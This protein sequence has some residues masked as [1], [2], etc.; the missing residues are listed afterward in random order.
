MNSLVKDADLRDTDGSTVPSTAIANLLHAA[1]GLDL[2]S[3]LQRYSEVDTRL[4]Y[5]QLAELYEAAARRTG[6][7]CFGL[8]VGASLDERR[9][10]LI[11]YL[12][13]TSGSIRQIFEVLEGYLPLW[14]SAARF[15]IER[16]RNRFVVEWGYADPSVIWRQ[17]CEMS[18]M[19]VVGFGGVLSTGCWRPCEVHFSHPSPADPSEHVRLLRAPVRFGMPRNAVVLDAEAAATPIETADPTLHQLLR[20]LADERLEPRISV[21]SIVDA[22]RAEI[23]KLLPTGG[24]PL[25]RV[26]KRLGIGPRTLQRRLVASG[27]TF[28]ALLNATRRDRA[29]H[30][31]M[32]SEMPINDLARELGYLSATEFHRAF[33]SWMGVSPGAYRRS[34]R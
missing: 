27:T 14:T 26:A 11:G 30:A 10:G 28:R 19:T 12:V 29:T 33:R 16:S 4:P 34:F 2:G 31:L 8:H 21:R 23:S 18:V 13:R 32:H 1:N 20:T 24:A 6:D 17:D 9:F 3:E 25:P 22:T 5:R 7:P 15:Q